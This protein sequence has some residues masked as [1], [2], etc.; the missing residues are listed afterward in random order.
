MISTTNL[1]DLRNGELIA[2]L[3]NLFGILDKTDQ[4][5]SG[6]KGVVDKLRSLFNTLK[7]LYKLERGSRITRSLI[8][9]DQLRDAL[10]VALRMILG[11]HAK[12]HPDENLRPAAKALLEEL[13]KYGPDLYRKSY[14]EQTTD[15]RSICETI[16]SKQNLLDG[17]AALSLDMYYTGMKTA[18][19][20]FDQA[21]LERNGEYA[22]I[23]KEKMTELRT[24][25]EAVFANLAKR[26][27]AHMVLADDPAVYEAMAKEIDMLVTTYQDAAARRRTE[28]KP[29]EELDE[30]YNET[31]ET[32]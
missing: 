16:D 12:V 23:P 29:N 4:E 27:N 17:F 5:S 15:M 28:E 2:F 26:I 3:A 11:Q 1:H 19:E 8:E 14:Q 31:G 10:F 7:E 30:D 13:E 24:E 18:N 32:E 20:D 21:Y 6:L 22:Q 9:L 25:T